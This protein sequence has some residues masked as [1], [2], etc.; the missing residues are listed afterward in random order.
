MH[1]FVSS[2]HKVSLEWSW[3][4]G[5]PSAVSPIRSLC[6]SHSSSTFRMTVSCHDRACPHDLTL[7]TLRYGHAQTPTINCAS[8]NHTLPM[9]AAAQE[10]RE[11]CLALPKDAQ[12]SCLVRGQL[13]ASRAHS[14]LCQQLHSPLCVAT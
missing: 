1:A 2:Q 11:L 4:E 13:L 8:Q 12:H 9:P 3:A 5:L 10:D 7:H 6:S 14:V